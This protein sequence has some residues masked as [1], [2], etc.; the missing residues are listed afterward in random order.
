[1]GFSLGLDTMFDKRNGK[2]REGVGYR[3]P[4]PRNTQGRRSLS[5]GKLPDTVELD[6]N[7]NEIKGL[8]TRL[9]DRNEDRFRGRGGN[10]KIKRPANV[11]LSLSFT[12]RDLSIRDNADEIKSIVTNLIDTNNQW[13]RGNRLL[14]DNSEGRISTRYRLPPAKNIQVDT[15]DTQAMVTHLLE[16]VRSQGN[17]IDGKTEKGVENEEEED[18]GYNGDWRHRLRRTIPLLFLICF[19]LLYILV[20]LRVQLGLPIGTFAPVSV[21][22]FTLLL[23]LLGI[24][25]TT[26]AINAA[27]RYMTIKGLRENEMD[28]ISGARS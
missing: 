14:G 24:L 10:R 2:G 13:R 1:M 16:R 11:D 17:H 18:W 22:S 21:N 12:T 8:I 4:P 6:R 23:I 7:S 15:K 9:I 5:L 25:F 27:L 26:V 28:K 19:P 3:K 20:F